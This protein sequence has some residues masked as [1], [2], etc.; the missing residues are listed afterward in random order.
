MSALGARGVGSVVGA[1]VMLAGTCLGGGAFA[2]LQDGRALD[3]NPAV[4]GDGKN[5]R[6]TDFDAIR[7]F[8][9]SVINGTAGGG[10]AFRGVT[11]YRAPDEFRGRGAAGSTLYGFRRD[12]AA[13]GLGGSGVR[14]SD[15][16]QWQFAAATGQARDELNPAIVSAL[17]PSRP[18]AAASGTTLRSL[19]SIA[20]YQAAE[21]RK[22]S[23]LSFIMDRSTGNLAM[24]E[25]SSLRGLT[26]TQVPPAELRPRRA[27]SLLNPAGRTVQP[28]PGGG[29]SGTT[30]GTAPV[31][32]STPA[33]SGAVGSAAAPS[34][35]TATPLVRSA[36]ES[37]TAA[38]GREAGRI[39]AARTPPAP[40][41]ANTPGATPGANSP[42]TSPGANTPGASPS[43]GVAS[44]R[45]PAE[46]LERLR[47]IM[48]TG[49]DPASAAAPGADGPASPRD[50]RPGQTAERGSAADWR[51]ELLG[52]ARADGKLQ[53][54]LTRMGVTIARPK[55]RPPER[56][57]AP[58][59]TNVPAAR[60]PS[61]PA[62]SARVLPTDTV[63]M[64]ALRDAAK[65]D[66]VVRELIP[67]D[68]PPDLEYTMLMRRGVQELA[69]GA[70]FDA[71]SSFDRAM[72]VRGLTAASGGPGGLAM[73]QAGRLHAQI[74][75][76]LL[77]SASNSTRD[78]LIANPE[79][80]P[81]RFEGTIL[82][83]R[84]RV[85][86]IVERVRSEV[87]RGGGL[88]IDGQWILAYAG[89][90]YRQQA[91]LEEGLAALTASADR[92][93]PADRRL[94]ELLRA[95]WLDE[96]APAPPAAP[97]SPAEPA[98]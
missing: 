27:D 6:G 11:G 46:E 47:A 97:A 12:S 52:N 59:P 21:A 28:L 13:S 98:K 50:V 19:R 75:A 78:L 29:P 76:G 71:E 79:L 55:P 16:L 2:Q 34:A 45:T 5:P 8:N 69:A 63:I 39:I 36:Y 85:E 23:P 57:A 84:A 44:A 70:N 10:K 17:S 9:D 30:P 95:V 86:Q 38:V 40:G 88:A 60:P 65:A 25:V 62:D 49:V 77:V 41:N 83:P 24:V 42:G 89:W 64:D 87:Q 37:A 91:W 22:P 80:V 20:D 26:A 32:G 3:R 73:A 56:P 54:E 66:T 48:T 15:I 31:P 61:P 53:T 93:S 90:H 74:A 58:G 68:A 14:S 4:Y 51:S 72:K 33:T 67:A 82:P 43:G 35:R 81:V 7:R 94:L 18:G 1:L 92:L 96:R